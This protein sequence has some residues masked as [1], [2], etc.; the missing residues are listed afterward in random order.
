MHLPIGDN[1]MLSFAVLVGSVDSYLTVNST[2]VCFQQAQEDI[3]SSLSNMVKDSLVNFYRRILFKP[4][5]TAFCVLTRV[6]V[7]CSSS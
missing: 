6:S 2:V 3:I 7:L 4:G 1:R 5:T